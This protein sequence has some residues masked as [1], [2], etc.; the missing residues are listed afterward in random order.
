MRVDYCV[1]VCVCVCVCTCCLQSFA[2]LHIESCCPSQ[3]CQ[4]WQNLE[5][6]YQQEKELCESNPR[7]TKPSNGTAAGLD[8]GFLQSEPA[9]RHG[10]S[11]DFGTGAPLA[12]QRERFQ[13][14]RL[15]AVWV[16]GLVVK[17]KG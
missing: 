10:K 16:H 8:G 12:K 7:L 9:Q 1:N 5:D 4:V 14:V 15:G 6:T 11:L 13:K 17:I 2:L 3:N